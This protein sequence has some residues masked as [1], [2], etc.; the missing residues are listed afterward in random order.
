MQTKTQLT[1]LEWAFRWLPTTLLAVALGACSSGPGTSMPAS[2]AYANAA[3]VSMGSITG[4]GS[5]HVNG[6]KFETT[7][8]KITV[9]GQVAMQTDLKVGDVV[10]VQDHHDDS[11][12]ASHL[13][14]VLAG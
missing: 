3:R 6:V 5:V 4:F 10:S 12:D 7:S 14:P 13:R 8:A 11:T 2:S 9:N 1:Y